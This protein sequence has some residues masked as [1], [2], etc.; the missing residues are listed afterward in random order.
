VREP[1]F[2]VG[3]RRR[4]ERRA[5]ALIAAQ[6]RIDEPAAPSPRIVRAA[7]T[8]APGCIGATRMLSW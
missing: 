6:H 5:L 1:C 2:V 7:S 4:I 8:V 3:I